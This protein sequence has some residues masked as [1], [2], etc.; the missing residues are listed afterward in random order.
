[1]NWVKGGVALLAFGLQGATLYL[2]AQGYRSATKA[3]ATV[4]QTAIKINELSENVKALAASLKPP[5][6]PVEP[7]ERNNGPTIQGI[8]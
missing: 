3:Q 1:M 7:P 5:E 2:V 8:E 4:D 6:K